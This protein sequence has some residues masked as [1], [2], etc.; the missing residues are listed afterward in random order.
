MRPH[1]LHAT[2]PSQHDDTRP[3]LLQARLTSALAGEHWLSI[4]NGLANGWQL[5]GCNA[6]N[7]SPKYMKTLKLINRQ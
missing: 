7:N 5:V 2:Y 4:E 6:L 3:T 1:T